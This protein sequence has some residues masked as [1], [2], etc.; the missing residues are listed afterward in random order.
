MLQVNPAILNNQTVIEISRTDQTQ[1]WILMTITDKDADL[2]GVPIPELAKIRS[3]LVKNALTRAWQERQP[4]FLI[5]QFFIAL[6][7]IIAMVLVPNG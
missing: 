7:I 6:G 2:Y 1:Q 4:K 5:R 3:Y